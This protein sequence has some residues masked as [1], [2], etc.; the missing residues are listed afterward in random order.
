MVFYGGFKGPWGAAPN[1]PE[2]G[3]EARPE[4]RKQLEKNLAPDSRQSFPQISPELFFIW[5]LRTSQQHQHLW[6]FTAEVQV[7]MPR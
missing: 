2:T 7:V 4:D 1:R 6:Q 5:A 3:P